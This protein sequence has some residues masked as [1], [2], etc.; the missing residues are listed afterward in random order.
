MAVNL[1]NL[2]T[3]ISSTITVKLVDNIYS[4]AQCLI[5][6]DQHKHF[7]FLLIYVGVC[8]VVSEVK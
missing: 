7:T 4:K 6:E 1:L 3:H 2:I 5:P 8:G